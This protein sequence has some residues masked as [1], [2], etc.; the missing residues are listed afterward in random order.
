MPRPRHGSRIVELPKEHARIE[1][2]ERFACQM[3]V[4]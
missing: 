4:R 2:A 1:E 3:G